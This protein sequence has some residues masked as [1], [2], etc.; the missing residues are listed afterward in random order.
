MGVNREYFYRKLAGA[1]AEISVIV[2]ALAPTQ[3]PGSRRL[4]ISESAVLIILSG[5]YLKIHQR[6][7]IRYLIPTL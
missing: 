7:L 5:F 2:A 6:D 1:G 4:R 3:K